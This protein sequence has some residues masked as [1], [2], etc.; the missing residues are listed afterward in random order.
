MIATSKLD[1]KHPRQSSSFYIFA[2]QPGKA[3]DPM[4]D[5]TKETGEPQDK[6]GLGPHINTGRSTLLE[7]V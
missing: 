3:E 6:M 5:A 7:T 4:E 2:H 1:I